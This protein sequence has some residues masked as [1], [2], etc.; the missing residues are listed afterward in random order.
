MTPQEIFDTV[1]KHL[2]TQGKP[3]K[4][5]VP[6]PD[7]DDGEDNQCRYRA[8]DG[9]KCAVGVLIPDELYVESMEG[10]SLSGLILNLGRQRLPELPSWMK[11]NDRL[12][13]D[14]QATHDSDFYWDATKRMRDRLKIV[15]KDCG[16]DA[17][18]LATLSFN[19]PKSE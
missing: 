16:L 12:L 5:M 2:F 14:L 11:E 9:T 10:Q 4:Q 17:S 1:A 6:D 3:A 7:S 15:A 13:M 18:I 8:A 19:R